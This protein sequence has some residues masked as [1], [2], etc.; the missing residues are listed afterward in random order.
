MTIASVLEVLITG[1]ARPLQLALAQASAST[2]AFATTTTAASRSTTAASKTMMGGLGAVKLTAVGAGIALGIFAKNAVQSA[3]AYDRAFGRIDAITNTSAERIDVMKQQIIAL[4]GQTAQAPVEL[5]ESFYFLA[6]AG[7]T[8]TEQNEALIATAKGAAVGLGE[9]KDIAIVTA[10]ALNLYAQSGLEA[11]DVVDTLVAA[12]RE[13]TAEPEAFAGALG[14]VLPVAEK[15]G[16]AFDEVTASLATMSNAGLDVHEGVTAIRAVM[17]SLLAP[18]KQTVDALASIG[19]T[20]DDV[21]ESLAEQGLIHTL[22]MLDEKTHGNIDTLRELIPNIRGM[23]GAFNLTEQEAAEVDRIFQRVKDSTGD[24]ARAFAATE[25]NDAF[26]L[27]QAMQQ[28]SNSAMELGADVLPALATV[29]NVVADAFSGVFAVLEDAPQLVDLLV[30]A[31]VTLIGLKIVSFFTGWATSAGAAAVA[32]ADLA[33]AQVALDAASGFGAARTFASRARELQAL[34]NGAAMLSSAAPQ[35]GRFAASLNI[36]ELSL[37]RLGPVA[38]LAWGALQGFKEV[39]TL[40]APED[41]LDFEG[42]FQVAFDAGKWFTQMGHLD[43][44]PTSIQAHDFASAIRAVDDALMAGMMTTDEAITATHNLAEEYGVDLPDNIDQVIRKQATFTREM[45]HNRVAALEVIETTKDLNEELKR[46]AQNAELSGRAFASF[47]DGMASLAS[48]TGTS[49]RS[50]REAGKAAFVED[51]EMFGENWHKFTDSVVQDVIDMRDQIA[52]NVNFVDEEFAS[53]LEDKT[54]TAG[55]ILDAFQDASAATKAFGA[56]L[57][58]VADIGNGAGADLSLWLSS[59]GPE[60]AAAADTIANSSKQMQNSMV[61]AFNKGQAAADQVAN[62]LQRQIVG[63]LKDILGWLKFLVTGEWNI[64]MGSNGKKVESD[65]R[66]LG[67]Q[68]FAL[69]NKTWIIKMGVEGSGGIPPAANPA[70]GN[71]VPSGGGGG[72]GGGG[73]RR[74]RDESYLDRERFERDHAYSREYEGWR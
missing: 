1:D 17:Q 29:M 27:E 9:A 32:T 57:S 72:G 65:I 42:A 19:L 15:A 4:S 34:A 74:K 62:R 45:A 6:S 35:V 37:A 56:D 41:G 43:L 38:V 67:E 53:V 33:A 5:A 31:L 10:Q 7:L 48:I 51:T 28:L 12:V 8:V 55:S 11:T 47:N 64:H 68:L 63:T 3:I 44:G 66:S 52:E 50:M 26:R 69:T 54:P 73:R 25:K 60:G 21:R 18:T 24:L 71:A 22:R 2:S 30:A 61:T 16:I 36:L 70:S 46:N 20:A 40:F 14:R 49:I 13:G 39:K 23:V 59:L 58:E